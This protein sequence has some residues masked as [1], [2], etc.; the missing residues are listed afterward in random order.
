MTA[1]PHYIRCP[2]HAQSAAL[3]RLADGDRLVLDRGGRSWAWEHGGPRPERKVVAQLL[4]EEWAYPP[5]PD[6]P[7]F[8]DPGDGA[9]SGAGEQALDHYRNITRR[10]WGNG[11][12]ARDY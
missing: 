5:H 10:S 6:G 8:G 3:Q 11:P 12:D 2:T 7:L 1:E 4:A 9:L